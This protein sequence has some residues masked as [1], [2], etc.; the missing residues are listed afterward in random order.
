MFSLIMWM[1]LPSATQGHTQMF[2]AIDKTIWDNNH[3]NKLWK[4]IRI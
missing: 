4:K 2:I 3:Q 1:S